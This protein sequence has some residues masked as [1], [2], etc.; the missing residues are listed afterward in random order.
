MSNIDIF[1]ER[2]KTTNYSEL[3]AQIKNWRD[4]YDLNIT[5]CHIITLVDRLALAG[6]TKSL[7][8]VKL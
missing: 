5:D 1:I 2:T 7:S 4:D 8:E 6:F 3:I